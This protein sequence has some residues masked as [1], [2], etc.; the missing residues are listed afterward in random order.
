M[1][2]RLK[3][4]GYLLLGLSLITA[5]LLGWIIL[6]PKL[7]TAK[8]LMAL[9]SSR[10]IDYLEDDELLSNG[11]FAACCCM[12]GDIVVDYTLNGTNGGI[13][14]NQ[15]TIR[16]KIVECQGDYNYRKWSVDSQ[17]NET[18]SL[19]SEISIYYNTDDHT[20]CSF[21]DYSYKHDPNLMENNGIFQFLIAF[22]GL[23]FVFIG[24]MVI[25]THREKCISQGEYQHI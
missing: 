8:P 24:L 5:G 11:K 23:V 6:I 19:Q 18:Y 17:L 13:D 7:G 1:N 21:T 4:A 22:L 20:D 10:V 2:Q 9:A 12:H 3:F 25:I 16:T 15:C 14:E